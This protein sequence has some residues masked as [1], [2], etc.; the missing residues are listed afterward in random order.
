MKTKC[1]LL[2]VVTSTLVTMFAIANMSYARAKA[3]I[4]RAYQ[5]MTSAKMIKPANATTNSDIVLRLVL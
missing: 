4:G 1:A 5:G 3:S 2:F